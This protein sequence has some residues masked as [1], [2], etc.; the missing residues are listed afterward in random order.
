VSLLVNSPYA[1]AIEAVRSQAA[2]LASSPVNL[3]SYL[4]IHSLT[5]SMV[6]DIIWKADCH[7]A[8]QKIS[9]FLYV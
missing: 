6:Q 9:C 4:L 2:L 8:C 7:S 1:E 5:H 3:D